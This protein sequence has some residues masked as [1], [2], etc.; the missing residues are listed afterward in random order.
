MRFLLP[1]LGVVAGSIGCG[2][3]L[4][5]K[6]K[7][8]LEVVVKVTSDPSKPLE[9]A[10]VVYAGKTIATTDETG[11]AKLTLN[12]NDGDSYEVTIKCP[13]GFQSPTKSTVIPLRRL[14]GSTPEY[15]VTC[16]PTT[17][18]AVVAVRA[19]NGAFLPIKHLGRVVGRTD[20]AGAATVLLK[21]V[22]A[23][24]PIELVLD[25]TEK[26]ME[27]LRPQ[28]PSSPAFLLKRGDEV[29]TFDQKFQIE[30]PKV[31][32]WYAPKKTGPIALPTKPGN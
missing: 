30:A 6:P 21:D 23:D 8:A 4:A 31:K 14:E 16:P 26:G 20:G 5:V 17:R 9:G 13:T 15:D 11:Q 2:D 28:N 25:T 18:T 7:P 27:V 29:F 1:L 3:S 19:E 24:T 12:G 32:V 10:K 22:E